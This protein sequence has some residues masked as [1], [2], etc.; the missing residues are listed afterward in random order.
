MGLQ[1]NL[2]RWEENLYNVKE[3]EFIFSRREALTQLL[4]CNKSPI[5]LQ[6]CHSNEKP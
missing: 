2:E 1:M 6:K 3:K 5:Q 4:G